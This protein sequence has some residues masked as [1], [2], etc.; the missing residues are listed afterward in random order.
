MDKMNGQVAIVTGAGRGIGAGIALELAARGAAVALMGRTKDILEKSAEIIRQRTAGHV[1]VHVGDVT[2]EASVEN[3]IDSVLEKHK[4][5]D[6]LVNNAGIIDQ[7]GF[8]DIGLTGWNSVISTNLTGVFLMTQRVARRMRTTGGGSIVNIASIDAYGTDGPQ[9][10]YTVAKAGVIGLTK[11][12]ATELAPI[13]V[14]VNS[15]SPGWVH[16]QMVE[17][18]VSANAMKYLLGNFA[19]VPMQR[20]VEINEVARAVAFLSRARQL[21]DYGDRYA[22]RLRDAFK[23]LCIRDA[24][25]VAVCCGPHRCRGADTRSVP[26]PTVLIRQT[27]IEFVPMTTSKHLSPI[28][29]IAT[30]ELVANQ[31]QRAVHLGL[32]VPEIAFRQNALSPNSLV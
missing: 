19:R 31:I 21:G 11:V 7:A 18:F 17:E 27:R 25:P 20:L 29:A 24:S 30:Y 3:V 16:T 23:S 2:A 26:E 32:L 28:K 13:K 15:V 5:I 4:R 9:A 1:S 12:A 22:G 14:R 8:L 6:I 10:S